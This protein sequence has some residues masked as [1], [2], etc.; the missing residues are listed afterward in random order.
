M[1]KAKKARAPTKKGSLAAAMEA[2]AARAC[3][4]AASDSASD[5]LQALKDLGVIESDQQLPAPENV[6]CGSSLQLGEKLLKA[7][8]QRL[9]LPGLNPSKLSSF[10]DGKSRHV[11][12]ASQLGGK[13]QGWPA[14]VHLL[15]MSLRLVQELDMAARHDTPLSRGLDLARLLL[16]GSEM[17]QGEAKTQRACDELRNLDDRHVLIGKHVTGLLQA[18]LKELNTMPTTLDTLKA[19]TVLRSHCVLPSRGDA[20]HGLELPFGRELCDGL[21]AELGGCVSVWALAAALASTGALGRDEANCQ[22]G[23]KALGFAALGRLLTAAEALVRLVDSAIPLLNK[24]RDLLAAKEGEGPP[25]QL[26]AVCD[27]LLALDENDAARLIGKHVAGLLQARLNS[28]LLCAA[29]PTMLDALK[30]MTVLR[31]HCVLPSREDVTHGLKLPFG[32]ELCDGL[33]AELGGCVSMIALAAA[34]ASTGAVGLT[35]ASLQLGGKAHGFAALGRLLAAAGA[36]TQWLALAKA[37]SEVPLFMALQSAWILLD[38][39]W[40]QS[41]EEQAAAQLQSL[42]ACHLTLCKEGEPPCTAVAADD[43]KGESSHEDGGDGR[44]GQAVAAFVAELLRCCQFELLVASALSLGGYGTEKQMERLL[45]ARL[46]RLFVVVGVGAEGKIK[47]MRQLL[48]T[49]VNVSHQTAS[50]YTIADVLGAAPG[51]QLQGGAISAIS[52]SLQQITDSKPM[53]RGALVLAST[54]L[55]AAEDTLH[56]GGQLRGCFAKCF[57]MSSWPPTESQW[58]ALKLDKRLQ[59]L[60]RELVYFFGRIVEAEGLVSEEARTRALGAELRHRKQLLGTEPL[61]IAAAEWASHL[62][63]PVPLDSISQGGHAG[64]KAVAVCF[65]EAPDR[66][67][68]ESQLQDLCVELVDTVGSWYARGCHTRNHQP[69]AW[70]G[71]IAIRDCHPSN[72]GKVFRMTLAKCVA[73]PATTHP[74]THPPTHT[75]T[76]THTNAGTTRSPLT[77]ARGGQSSA[78]TTGRRYARCRR[79]GRAHSCLPTGAREGTRTPFLFGRARLYSMY[80]HRSLIHAAT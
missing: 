61:T 30:A 29:M 1:A 6:T 57:P 56:D 11:H 38:V 59:P 49:H 70:R 10:L 12:A 33:H 68:L 3:A 63:T 39:D 20:A 36:L 18:R 13:A 31:S 43:G 2:R 7:L 21:R 47:Q 35:E 50:G 4:T 37:P 42:Q 60:E 67:L 17:E 79:S 76:H 52:S 28:E 53:T 25:E 5:N 54:V 24:A 74:P 64:L 8:Q 72:M 26:K 16:D 27:R 55:A 44:V 66:E 40:R 14:L 15:E 34:L 75:H 78:C 23:G 32:R 65:R 22:L 19:M 46:W 73:A 69:L 51:H 80:S 45:A 9:G 77:R 58:A 62:P 71:L 48:A 41:S